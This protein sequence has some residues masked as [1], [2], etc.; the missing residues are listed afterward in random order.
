MKLD[1]KNLSAVNC[2]IDKI[3]SSIENNSCNQVPFMWQLLEAV[4]IKPGQLHAHT[5]KTYNIL[6]VVLKCMY[7]EKIVNIFI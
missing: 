1:V 4:L 7:L 3:V 2:S 6:C 5:V